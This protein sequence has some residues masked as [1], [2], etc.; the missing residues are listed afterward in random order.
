MTSTLQLTCCWAWTGCWVGTIVDAACTLV[1][2]SLGSDGIVTVGS[3][4]GGLG[5]GSGAGLGIGA[6]LAS[7]LGAG[8][9][10]LEPLPVL[11]AEQVLVGV[12]VQAALDRVGGHARGL[13]GRHQGERVL[14]A[15]PRRADRGAP[16]A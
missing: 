14:F 11:K 5:S 1:P 7:G 12:E 3:C 10:L 6:G 15:H 8:V 16:L 2:G 13:Q 9:A 4:A